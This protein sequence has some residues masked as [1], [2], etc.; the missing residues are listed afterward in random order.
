MSGVP[1]DV[2]VEASF[3]KR[4]NSSSDLVKAEVFHFT[5]CVEEHGTAAFNSPGFSYSV[6]M[7]AAGFP[8]ERF[9]VWVKVR[10]TWTLFLI[11]NPQPGVFVLFDR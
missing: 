8:D 3:Q 4:L 9:R 7:E 6:P 11:A 2:F 5:Q 1:N 10:G